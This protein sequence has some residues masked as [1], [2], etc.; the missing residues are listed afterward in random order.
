MQQRYYEPK[1][2]SQSYTSTEN[3]S[4]DTHDSTNENSSSP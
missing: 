1:N 4:E 3:Y 2:V